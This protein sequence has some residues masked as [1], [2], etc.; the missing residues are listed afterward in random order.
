VG[1]PQVVD[2]LISQLDQALEQMGGRVGSSTEVS[3]WRLGG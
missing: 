2:L 3:G 1:T